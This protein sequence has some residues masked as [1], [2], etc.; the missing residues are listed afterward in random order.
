MVESFHTIPS[1]LF[2]TVSVSRRYKTLNRPAGSALYMALAIWTEIVLQ[3]GNMPFD[4]QN[5]ARV[6]TGTI[7]LQVCPVPVQCASSV[8]LDTVAGQ[9][10]VPVRNITR[11]MF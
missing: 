10:A 8:A 7:V 3:V 2:T 5:E 4:G 9:H 11:Q 6:S 1:S